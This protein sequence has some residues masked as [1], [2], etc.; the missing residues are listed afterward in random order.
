MHCT[1]TP[2]CCLLLLAFCSYLLLSSPKPNLHMCSFARHVISTGG[3][4]RYCS[5]D[6]NDRVRNLQSS[7]V[8][9]EIRPPLVLEL[10][11]RLT[12]SLRLFTG[13]MNSC[14]YR[15]EVFSDVEID[16]TLLK[17]TQKNALKEQSC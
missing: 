13:K 16:V 1:M 11:Y 4:C 15:K 12:D 6:N 2:V 10:N 8:W 3:I 9:H 17:T 5:T 14:L 7:T